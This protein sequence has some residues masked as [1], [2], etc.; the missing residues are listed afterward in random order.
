MSRVD[1]QTSTVSLFFLCKY[2]CFSFILVSL[3]IS[4]VVC[5]F[6]LRVWYSRL[7]KLLHKLLKTKRM[8]SRNYVMT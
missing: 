8:L 2:L 7:G 4:Y 5:Y 1:D 6:L 3:T